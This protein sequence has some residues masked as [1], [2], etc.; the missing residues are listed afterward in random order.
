VGPG[1]YAIRSR[2]ITK[3]TIEIASLPQ[4]F[5]NRPCIVIAADKRGATAIGPVPF[6][7]CIRAKMEGRGLVRSLRRA[8]ATR[9][10]SRPGLVS[11]KRSP[12]GEVAFETVVLCVLC[13]S[14]SSQLK[15]RELMR[16]DREKPGG[17]RVDDRCFAPGGEGGSQRGDSIVSS[18]QSPLCTPFATQQSVNY[19]IDWNLQC[20]LKF[21]VLDTISR[22]VSSLDLTNLGAGKGKPASG[23]LASGRHAHGMRCDARRMSRNRYSPICATRVGCGS[24]I[25]GCPQHCLTIVERRHGLDRC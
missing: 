1:S 17:L 12:V 5:T 19:C 9:M 23:Y 14:I 11:S 16:P 3:H 24:L 6:T 13:P 20:S 10:R 25:G 2:A 22:L 15:G 18:D 4:P 21:P 8:V 7:N